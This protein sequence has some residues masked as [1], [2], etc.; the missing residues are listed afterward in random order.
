MR[1]KKIGG[2][3][4]TFLLFFFATIA[5]AKDGSIDDNLGKRIYDVYKRGLSSK[6]EQ[7]A[8]VPSIGGAPNMEEN[9][10]SVSPLMEAIYL[11]KN[12]KKIKESGIKFYGWLNAGG[13]LSTS[14]THYDLSVGTGGNAPSGY[15]DYAN[16]VMLNQLVLNLEK[17]P[18]VS[19]KKKISYGFRISTL[20]GT[21]YQYTIASHLL[22]NQLLKNR[23]KYGFDPFLIYGDIYI[24]YVVEGLNIR[25]GRYAT[26]HDIE[27]SFA[28]ANYTYGHSLLNI[29]D[30]YTHQGAVATLK[31]NRNWKTQ[32]EIYNG[33]DTSIN[34]KKNDR[35]SVGACV[36][37]TSDD[38]D[39]KIYPCITGLNGGKYSYNNLQMNSINW[40][41][42]FN[43]KWS[44]ASQAYYAWQDRVPNANNVNSAA[45]INGTRAAQCNSSD[46]TC[47]SS[48]VAAA[49]YLV[50]QF[51]AKDFFTLR[52][53][54]FKDNH[55][56]RTGYNTTY[57]G[58]TIG[59]THAIGSVI[60]IRP[61]LRF[62]H[63]Y[64]AKVY[65]GGTK[66]SQ[67]IAA[68]DVIVYF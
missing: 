44:M 24:P 51:S 68:A 63:S 35:A 62:D 55:G 12:G 20:Y 6:S 17:F 56:Q 22:S 37:F 4:L 64:N 31:L 30:P 34:D 2:L 38:G 43:D 16:Q 19:Q 14:K 8:G 65:N 10:D 54:L 61:E 60:K 40:Y 15:Y 1:I 27:S 41:H 5:N 42:K 21:D 50:Y 26:L 57:S 3:L 48:S 18:D 46:L 9:D 52:N 33:S 67:C 47:K 11:G 32:F 58:H 13:N 25:V 23:N 29:F 66:S 39:D 53:D 59:W 45:P 7:L 28:P 36:H 49:H